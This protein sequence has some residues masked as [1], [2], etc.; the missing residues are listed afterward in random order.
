MFLLNRH[1][2]RWHPLFSPLQ[3]RNELEKHMNCNL[4][5]F[6][7]FIDNEML[8]ILGQ[9]DKPSLIFDHLYLVSCCNGSFRWAGDLVG[10]SWQGRGLRGSWI[11]CQGWIVQCEQKL[12]PAIQ[13]S[14]GNIRGL[15]LLVKAM[16]ILYFLSMEIFFL[17]W[18]KGSSC[19]CCPV[20][21]LVAFWLW[22]GITKLVFSAEP[23]KLCGQNYLKTKAE[24]DVGD[25]LFEF[26][27]QAEGVR[28][29]WSFATRWYCKQNQALPSGTKTCLRWAH[30]CPL[31]LGH[32]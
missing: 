17:I 19:G 10:G 22:W 21:Q 2:S 5:E 14:V 23:I 27:A 1:D 20:W 13:P 25:A 29:V 15:V 18:T 6:K 28:C 30:L 11:W 26:Y 12:Q 31:C 24:G 3:I 8:L 7:E 4:K 32:F 16:I 9:M